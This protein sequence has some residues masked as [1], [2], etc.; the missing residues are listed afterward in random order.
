MSSVTE[1]YSLVYGDYS[2]KEYLRSQKER[3]IINLS[4]HRGNVP[5]TYYPILLFC[6]SV[7]V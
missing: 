4:S 2:E 7:E 5:E 3:K 6:Q 1:D